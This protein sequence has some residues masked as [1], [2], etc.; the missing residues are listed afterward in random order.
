MLRVR[1]GVTDTVLVG[2]MPWSGRNRPSSVGS[3]G[4]N[5]RVLKVYSIPGRQKIA[6]DYV[7]GI[8]FFWGGRGCLRRGALAVNV[9]LWVGCAAV[10]NKSK[11]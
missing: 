7:R 9:E 2:P 4:F 3:G 10:R 11:P 1:V 8:S 6:A 5:F